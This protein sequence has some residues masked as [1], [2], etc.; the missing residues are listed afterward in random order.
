[1]R[2]LLFF[3]TML[4]AA[5]LLLAAAEVGLFAYFRCNAGRYQKS[6]LVVEHLSA[7]RRQTSHVMA[8][9]IVDGEYAEVALK[10][11]LARTG[12]LGPRE[13]RAALEAAGWSVPIYKRTDGE[14]FGFLVQGRSLNY[15]EADF[16]EHGSRR[17]AIVFGV[18]LIL[19][20]VFFFLTRRL[21]LSPKSHRQGRGA[22]VR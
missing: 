1:M 4:S 13:R 11:L 14:V 6:N 3:G 21:L 18:T 8:R 7:P 15:V 2:I 9:G 12:H 22:L 17:A 5:F 19:T 16:I 10:S 20:P